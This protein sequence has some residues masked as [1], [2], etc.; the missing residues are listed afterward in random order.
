MMADSFREDLFNYRAVIKLCLPLLGERPTTSTVCTAH[1]GTAEG[2]ARSR[3]RGIGVSHAR[4]LLVSNW[5][6]NARQLHFYLER[7]AL[8]SVTRALSICH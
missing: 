7:G 5:K 3:A 8:R 1:T 4:D 2:R 6:G